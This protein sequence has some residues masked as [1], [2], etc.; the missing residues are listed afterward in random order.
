MLELGLLHEGDHEH[1]DALAQVVEQLGGEGGKWL[2]RLHCDGVLL[3]LVLVRVPDELHTSKY[4]GITL[5]HLPSSHS[6]RIIF[7][8]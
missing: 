7:N 6:H 5:L 8:V 3:A 4:T 2:A 1:L